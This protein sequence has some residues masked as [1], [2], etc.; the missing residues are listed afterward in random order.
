M[1]SSGSGSALFSE[2]GSGSALASKFWSCGGSKWSLGGSYSW[3]NGH[4][5]N[6]GVSS[7]WSSRKS[8]DQWSQI[9]INLMRSRIRFWIRIKVK[10]R[11]RIRFKVKRC[12]RISIEVM[13]IHT[14]GSTFGNTY[15]AQL[16]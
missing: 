8:V 4:A 2:A 12:I 11:I 16:S 15:S 9:R 14:P 1:Q 7:I 5:Y 10:I 3:T 6:R 13:R